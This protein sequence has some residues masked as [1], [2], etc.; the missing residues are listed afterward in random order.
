MGKAE[1]AGALGG[2][3]EEILIWDILVRLPPKA[4]LRCRAVCRAWRS[5][6]STPDFLLAHHFRQPALPLVDNAYKYTEGISESL[7]IGCFDHRPGVAATDQ[8]Q[9]IARL[10]AQISFYLDATIGDDNIGDCISF[11]QPVASCDGLLIFS[12][13]D[14]DFF[15]CNPASRQYARLL[16]PMDHRWT[17]LGMYPHPLTGEYRLLLYSYRGNLDDDEPAPNSKF[18]C[19][20]LE[21][22]SGKPPRRIVWPDAITITLMG[23]NPHVLFH[24]N[25]HWYPLDNDGNNTMIVVFN[26][27]SESFREMRAPV[28]TYCADL[29]EIDDMLGMSAFDYVNT[30]D[31]WVLQDY[32]REVWA[33]NRRIELHAAEISVPYD[34]QLWLDVLVVPGDGQLVVLVKSHDWLLEVGMDG[35]LVDTFHHKKVELTH[36]RLKQT[37]VPHKFFPT[38]KGYVL[39]SPPFI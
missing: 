4:L 36:F 27:T 35:K 2:L 29:F 25:L 6:T 3:L 37:L 22:G 28:V 13:E 31:I 8:L 20:V 39:N 18:A 19:H 11:F 12:V 16:L 9:P 1:R 14:T 21:L 24:G 30:I 38:L 26:T 23:L 7:D 10:I 17:V 15:I 32:E 34:V 5:V 33:L